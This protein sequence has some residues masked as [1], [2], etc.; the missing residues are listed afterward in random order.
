MNRY[1]STIRS[2]MYVVIL[3][4][5][6]QTIERYTAGPWTLVSIPA[7]A[8]LFLIVACSVW[9]HQS[10][11]IAIDA[12]NVRI[13]PEGQGI[14]RE[15][16]EYYR[17]AVAGLT[18]LGF[19]PVSSFSVPNSIPNAIV[20]ATVFKNDRTSEVATIGNTFVSSQSFASSGIKT[21]LLVFL[22]EF[23]DGTTVA[24]NNNKFPSYLPPPRPP[25][26]AFAFPQVRVPARL[27]EVHQAVVGQFDE[28][29]VRR[30]P[31][32]DDPAAYFKRS[33]QREFARFLAC[34]YQYLDEAKG[35]QRPTWKG[36]FMAT[37]KLIWPV[38]QVRKVWRWWKAARM[39]HQLGLR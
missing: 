29:S 15:V 24:T 21:S 27:Y 14:P 18:P 25:V 5:A 34:G 12:E 31:I 13:D 38:K 8:L 28:G 6:F 23:A 7:F 19:K 10:Q 9:A 16:S 39:L 33:Q 4:F 17:H 37:V 35:V 36:A 3:Y 26:H 11:W 22:T 1:G 20:F 2:L 32:G 30:D